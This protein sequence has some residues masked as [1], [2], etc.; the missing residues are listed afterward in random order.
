MKYEITQE[1]YV[2]FLNTLSYDQQ[3]TRTT[4]DPINAAGTYAMSGA[5]NYRNG[6]RISVPGTNNVLPA[7]YACDATAGVEN[8]TND[9]QNVPV[10]TFSWGDLTAY[11][12]WAALRPMSDLEFEKICRGPLAR[13][14][15]EYPWGS[16]AIQAVYSTSVATPLTATE[17][18]SP[19]VNGLCAY[20]VG[21]SNIAYGPLRSGIFATGS[22]GRASSGATYFG[23][24]DMGGNMRER[25][26]TVSNS[27]GATYTGNTG[28][29]TL[30]TNGDPNQ[31]TWPSPTTAVG[32]GDRGGNWV[33]A[34]TE[35]RTSDR[36]NAATTD[37]ARTYVCGGRGVR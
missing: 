26:V 1:Q 21:T 28:D 11:L 29:G 25:I 2:G 37:A 7:V 35:V 13:V 34:A 36:S 27:T 30:T 12:D 18:Y 16:T 17:S 33:G 22:S 19:V 4:S 9:G 14:A 31:S 3:R 20:G 5:Y 15:A 6:I 23:V 8:N 32:S 24:M 10:S